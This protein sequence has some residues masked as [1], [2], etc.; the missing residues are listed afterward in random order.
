MKTAPVTAS[1]R[2]ASTAALFDVS[3]IAIDL[4]KDVF[5]VAHA[6]EQGRVIRQQRLKSREQFVQ[7]MAQWVGKTV[8]MESC[9]T[10]NFYG[11]ALWGLTFSQPP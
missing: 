8:V 2:A 6:D 7:A 9:A 11:R 10:A 5:Q 3:T 1:S 4:A